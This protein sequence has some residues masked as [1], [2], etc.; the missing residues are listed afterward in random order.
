MELSLV[1]KISDMHVGGFTDGE[2][3][4][5]FFELITFHKKNFKENLENYKKQILENTNT[6]DNYNEIAP[7]VYAHESAILDRSTAFDTTNG[8]IIIEANVKVLPFSYLVGPL[9][10]DESATINPH[11]NIS[12]SYIGKFCKIGGEV[13]NSVFEAYSNKGHYGYVGDSYVGSWVN[14]GAGTSTSNLKNTYGTIKMAGIETG[15][16]FIGSIIA[17]HV[18]TA[19]NTSIYTGKVIGVG[20]HIYSTVTSDVPNCVNYFGK[21]NITKIPMEVTEKTATRMM[22]R[23]NVKF[24]IEDKK[25]LELIYNTNE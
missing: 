4:K 11:T 22:E 7:N 24:S 13:S 6:K 25:L 5:E 19:L 23:R 18:K 9:R 2:K 3:P 16:Q 21:D 1:H 14:L 10:T 15:E 12:G 20:S 8:V 17:D